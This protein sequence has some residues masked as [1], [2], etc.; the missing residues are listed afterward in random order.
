MRKKDL[1][2][3]TSQCISFSPKQASNARKIMEKLAH[4]REM[5]IFAK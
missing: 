3:A 5:P 2:D 1:P 4:C